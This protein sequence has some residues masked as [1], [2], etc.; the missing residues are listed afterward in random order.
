MNNLKI[1]I[2]DN[3]LVIRAPLGEATLSSTGKSYIIAGTGGLM[4]TELKVKDR[5]VSVSLYVCIPIDKPTA[6]VDAPA[7]VSNLSALD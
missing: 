4:K 7:R 6:K 5:P 1:T 2:E 3:E